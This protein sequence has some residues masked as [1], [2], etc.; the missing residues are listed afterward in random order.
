QLAVKTIGRR[1]H[2]VAGLFQRSEDARHMLQKQFTGPRQPRTAAGADE[3]LLAQVF[4]QFLDGARQRRLLDVQP[5]GS[6][7]EVKFFGHG[8]EAAQMP[9]FHMPVV[10]YWYTGWRRHRSTTCFRTPSRTVVSA[11]PPVSSASSTS[12]SQPANCSH[13]VTPKPRVV[14]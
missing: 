10:R 3:Q 13:S 4:F 14:T 1:I 12:H 8:Q 9:Q 2:T 11:C 5:L 6:A 7:G